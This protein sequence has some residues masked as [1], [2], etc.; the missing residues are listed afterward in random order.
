MQLRPNGE[1]NNAFTAWMHDSTV[2]CGYVDNG[3]HIAS[4]HIPYIK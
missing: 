3:E 1:S 4:T 2:P